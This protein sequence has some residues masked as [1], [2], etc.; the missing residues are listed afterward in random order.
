MPAP[1]FD[2]LLAARVAADEHA[3]LFRFEST[4]WRWDE[5]CVKAEEAH[6][7][8][9]RQSVASQ[10]W[11]WGQGGGKVLERGANKELDSDGDIDVLLDSWAQQIENED[12][13]VLGPGVAHECL[14]HLVWP[15]ANFRFHNCN[16]VCNDKPLAPGALGVS[17]VTAHVDA[18]DTALVTWSRRS[19]SASGAPLPAADPPIEL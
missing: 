11:T 6:F 16:E 19:R 15:L 9:V 10:G 12:P 2:I 18:M 13:T 3:S 1:S 5:R 14:C 17:Q 4:D 7:A 8:R